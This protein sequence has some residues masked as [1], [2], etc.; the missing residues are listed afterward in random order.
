MEII[1]QAVRVIDYENNSVQRRNVNMMPKFKDYIEQLIVHVSNNVSIREYHTQSTRTEVIAGIL[2]IAGNLETPDAVEEKIDSIAERLVR[3]EREAQARIGHMNIS[4]QKGSL[5]FALFE[6]NGNR[7]CILAK[8]EHTGFF[9]ERDYSERFG[10]S[11]DTKKIWKTCMFDLNNLNADQFQAKIYSNTVAKY[12]WFDFLELVECQNDRVN[13]Y[14]TYDSVEKCLNRKLKKTAPYDNRVIQNA[15]YAYMNN[16]NREMFD[17]D[18]MI[19]KI[20]TGY[21]PN[22][23]TGE[24]K[25]ELHERLNRLPEEK[26]FD[27][28]FQAI[29]DA[30]KKKAIRTYK[31]N[32][33]IMLKISD[34]GN[35]NDISAYEDAYGKKY[36]KI[37]LSDDRTFQTFARNNE[38]NREE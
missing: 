27:R 1:A 5:I 11:K 38:D 6:D 22:D 36:L 7:K 37:R 21:M 12:W 18:N 31:I 35:E 32:T 2:E 19:E 30:I 13:T 15:M 25:R 10:F 4:V 16:A 17:Y 28:Q 24:Q 29:P 8:I 26:G 34:I 33:G 9:D 23:M 3:N 20:F 14:K